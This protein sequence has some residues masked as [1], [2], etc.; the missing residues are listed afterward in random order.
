MMNFKK[1]FE[2]AQERCFQE[3]K[4][5]A[6]LIP[7]EEILEWHWYVL[8]HMY[9]FGIWSHE[10]HKIF[11]TDEKSK[12]SNW[13]FFPPKRAFFAPILNNALKSAQKP[14]KVH[15]TG[16]KKPSRSS[17]IDEKS[18]RV[19]KRKGCVDSKIW[20]ILS[21]TYA[22]R[23]RWTKLMEMTANFMAKHDKFFHFPRGVKHL[24]TRQLFESFPNIFHTF[25]V[26]S[27]WKSIPTVGK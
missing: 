22:D 26:N 13:Q 24:T 16:P 23:E 10:H 8:T 7:P 12:F 4:L 14:S 20:E 11:K 2:I 3:P 1:T 9:Y 6:G 5:T 21:C 27:G 18:F 25:G 19:A 15:W 17:G